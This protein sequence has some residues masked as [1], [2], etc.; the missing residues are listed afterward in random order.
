M[1]EIST[2]IEDLEP[3]YFS[4]DEHTF[5]RVEDLENYHGRLGKEE[6]KKDVR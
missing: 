3:E 5:H 4:E 1:N 6:D 2:T